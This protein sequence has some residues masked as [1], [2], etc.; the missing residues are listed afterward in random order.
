MEY[1]EKLGK[2][3]V[4]FVSI[5]NDSDCFTPEDKLILLI[6]GGLPEYYSNSVNKETKKVGTNGGSKDYIAEPYPFV[7]GMNLFLVDPLLDLY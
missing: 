6:Q 7:V 3:D 5:E 1:F 4:G 2:A